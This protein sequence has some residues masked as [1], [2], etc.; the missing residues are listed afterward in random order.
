MM[1]LRLIDLLKEVDKETPITFEFREFNPMEEYWE[2][3]FCKTYKM[4]DVL[5]LEFE[6]EEI[7]ELL[8]IKIIDLLSPNNTSDVQIELDYVGEEGAGIKI[9][10]DDE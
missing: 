9:T 1:E 4:K 3:N 7:F 10:V 2:V 6:Q 8:S 5:F